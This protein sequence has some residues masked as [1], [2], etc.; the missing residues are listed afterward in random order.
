MYDYDGVW[1]G[2]TLKSTL[3][4]LSFLSGS[5]TST[6]A[7]IY[8]TS[9]IF[10]DHGVEMFSLKL[11]S[12][13]LS[14]DSRVPHHTP[15][16]LLRTLSQLATHQKSRSPIIAK[17]RLLDTHCIFWRLLCLVAK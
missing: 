10:Y 5:A 11:V 13:A 7:Q 8:N 2:R 4:P 9:K 12:D 15:D 6:R 3:P 14:V 17:I 16:E 1:R